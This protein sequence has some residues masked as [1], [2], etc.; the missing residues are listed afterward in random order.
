M[1]M[2][3]INI[4]QFKIY[5]YIWLVVGISEILSNNSIIWQ[6]SMINLS[7]SIQLHKYELLMYETQRGTMLLDY[8]S[9]HNVYVLRVMIV[10]SLI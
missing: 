8:L 3:F 5:I 6:C 10:I 2:V 9:M 4:K 7:K 1:F